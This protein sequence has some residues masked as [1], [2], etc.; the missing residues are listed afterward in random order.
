MNA[1][2][3]KLPAAGLAVVLAVGF[4]LPHSAPAQRVECVTP[5][6]RCAVAD[7][8]SPGRACRCSTNPGSL[9]VI[10]VAA[11]DRAL[12]EV[13]TAPTFRQGRAPP[14]QDQDRGS[15]AE[16]LPETGAQYGNQE[17]GYLSGEA[18]RR[19]REYGPET[20]AQYGNQRFL[21]YRD[22]AAD[23]RYGD[24]GRELLDGDWRAEW[25]Y[26]DRE[27]ELLDGDRRPEWR[28]PEREPRR[29]RDSPR[30][31]ALG[32]GDDVLAGPRMRRDR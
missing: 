31:D 22:P 21:P 23:L 29:L 7:E 16:R 9:G 32:E 3:V 2:I 18:A 20:G 25:R 28:Y 1:W 10:V 4:W 24:R 30:N 14:Y 27:R 15:R 26:R 17:R 13:Q 12:T 8:L 5:E 19:L 11:G 6:T